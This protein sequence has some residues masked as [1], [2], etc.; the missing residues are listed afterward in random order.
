MTHVRIGGCHRETVQDAFHVGILGIDGVIYLQQ[1]LV[2]LVRKRLVKDAQHCV[3]TVPDM[4]TT[5]RRAVDE[6]VKPRDLNDNAVMGQAVDK[7][8]WQSLRHDVI[9]VVV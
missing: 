3:Q 7:R 4:Q 8:V 5:G 1:A 9:I 2:V 6:A